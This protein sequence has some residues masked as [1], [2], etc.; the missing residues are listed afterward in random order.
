M[1]VMRRRYRSIAVVRQ[2]L[3]RL[4]VFGYKIDI[5]A[6]RKTQ[7]I[8]FSKR[9]YRLVLDL[10]VNRMISKFDSQHKA[11]P[12]CVISRSLPIGFH[13]YP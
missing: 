1:L 7:I 2:F 10:P 6:I 8:P 13:F 11:F 5:F 4:R 3:S 12:G 9:V